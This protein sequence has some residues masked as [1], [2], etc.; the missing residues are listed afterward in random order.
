MCWYETIYWKGVYTSCQICRYLDQV[1][2][3][4]F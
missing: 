3:T 2:T 4:C 1:Y